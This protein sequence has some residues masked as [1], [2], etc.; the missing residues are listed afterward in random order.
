VNQE[1]PASFEPNNQILP[2]TLERLDRLPCELGGD[3]P[4]IVRTGESRVFDL[5]GLDGA[6][7]EVGLEPDP[8]R[9]DLWQLG[10]ARSVAAAERV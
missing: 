3:L 7:D 9:L 4:R 6:A 1:N 8:D 5:D 2:A 10:H